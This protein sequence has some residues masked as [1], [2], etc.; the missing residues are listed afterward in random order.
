MNTRLLATTALVVWGITAVGAAYLFIGG[1]TIASAD[2]RTAVV[3]HEGERDLVLEEMRALLTSVQGI[4][5]GL[6]GEEMPR[7]R[8]AAASAGMAIAQEVPP[9]LMTK[10][11]LE[12]KQLGMQVHRNFDDIAAGVDQGEPAEMLLTRL[13]EQLSL[14]VG[15]H[16]SYRLQVEETH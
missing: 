12:F 15:C 11:P 13:G 8:Q 2:G 3:L 7:V 9:Q 4:V 6:A 16:A 14:C 5:A 10:L 1:K